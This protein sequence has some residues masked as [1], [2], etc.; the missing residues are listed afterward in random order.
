V[1]WLGVVMYLTRESVGATLAT[2]GGFAPGTQLVADYMVPAD[3]RDA[4]GTAYVEGVAPVAA[5]HGEPWLTSLTPDETA[6]LLTEHGFW[7]L[8]DVGQHDAIDPGLWKRGDGL[9]PASLSRL[10]YAEVR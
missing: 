2:I 8:A 1:S 4:A 10:V 7:V 3:L 6:A 5:E 9:T